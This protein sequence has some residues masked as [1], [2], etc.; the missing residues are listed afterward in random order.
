M[1]T[2]A[3]V[4]KEIPCKEEDKIIVVFSREYGKISIYA[5]GARKTKS[6]YLAGTQML[7]YSDFLIYKKD[8]LSN[9]SKIDLIDSFLDIKNDY[10]KLYLAMYFAEIIDALIIED[11]PQ[12]DLFDFFLESLNKLKK[13]KDISL[14]KSIF[15]LRAI[16]IAGYMPNVLTCSECGK[17]LDEDC[18]FI[19]KDDGITCTSCNTKKNGIKISKTTLYTLKYIFYMTNDKVYS[20]NVDDKYKKELK[21]V[22]EDYKNLMID[23]PLKSEKFLLD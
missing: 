1:N 14:M 4:L 9:L 3:I 5:K 20:F 10:E 8:N 11:M 19:S 18:Y 12:K 13:S 23:K 15:E 7:T 6:A 17:E 21:K 22:S 2:K 16:A